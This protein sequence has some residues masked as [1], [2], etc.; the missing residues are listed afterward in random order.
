MAKF[1]NSST[2]GNCTADLKAVARSYLSQ[3]LKLDILFTAGQFE[4]TLQLNFSFSWSLLHPPILLAASALS[5]QLDSYLTG[6]SFTSRPLR[7]LKATCL[8][9]G[10][11]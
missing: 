10:V 4:L 9:L 5:M 7:N 1:R 3:L 11:I 2:A 6:L 8:G